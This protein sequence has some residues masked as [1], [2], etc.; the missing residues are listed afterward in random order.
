MGKFS[1]SRI[2]SREQPNLHQVRT[3]ILLKWEPEVYNL[4][5][6]YRNIS[7]RDSKGPSVLPI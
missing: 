4:F 3:L 5:S 2:F 6:L 1:M 7:L